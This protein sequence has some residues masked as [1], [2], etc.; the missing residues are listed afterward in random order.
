MSRQVTKPFIIQVTK[1]FIIEVSFKAGGKFFVNTF[2][3]KR[4][5]DIGVNE[6]FFTEYLLEDTFFDYGAPVAFKV[7]ELNVPTNSIKLINWLQYEFKPLFEYDPL[8]WLASVGT[9][10]AELHQYLIPFHKDPHDTTIS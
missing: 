10:P 5:A 9:L 1:P 2:K 7:I 4:P 3:L 6:R 8:M